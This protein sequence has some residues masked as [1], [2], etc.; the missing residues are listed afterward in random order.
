M[1]LEYFAQ[2]TKKY[3]IIFST[4]NGKILQLKST[5]KLKYHFFNLPEI[6]YN[7]KIKI[8]NF[9]NMFNNVYQ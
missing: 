1:R 4:L 6:F 8:A 9:N 7:Y 5:E 3:N 2:N